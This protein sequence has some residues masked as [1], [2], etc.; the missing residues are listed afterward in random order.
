MKLSTA[1]S[2][3]N[4]NDIN[5]SWLSEI[6]FWFSQCHIIWSIWIWS[7]LLNSSPNTDKL[8]ATVVVNMAYFDL[9]ALKLAVINW[10]WSISYYQLWIF[11]A[12]FY[13]WIVSVHFF[14]LIFGDCYFRTNT[15]SKAVSSLEC[16]ILTWYKTLI[17]FCV[18]EFGVF[19]SWNQA[20]L[21]LI[22]SETLSCMIP[23]IRGN[24]PS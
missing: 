14:H 1:H 18:K 22:T 4:A 13:P 8:N 23:T 20:G 11:Y 7:H 12:Y 24:G 16:Y 17:F 9:K 21:A 5:P 10:I 2:N 3:S 6:Y 15:G 19:W